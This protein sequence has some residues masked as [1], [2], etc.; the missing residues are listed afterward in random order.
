MKLSSVRDRSQDPVW[1]SFVVGV[2]LVEALLLQK[3]MCVE[4]KK[5][6]DVQALQHIML[7]N[8]A[9]KALSQDH[10]SFS[11]LEGSLNDTLVLLAKMAGIA[12]CS[13]VQSCLEAYVQGILS[14]K[15]LNLARAFSDHLLFCTDCQECLQATAHRC[16][17]TIRSEYQASL[18]PV[19]A[20]YTPPFSDSLS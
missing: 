4:Q 17:N 16:Q 18:E 6:G 14:Y 19:I 11:E 1:S 10:R 9:S 2:L 20:A 15:S 8:R 3:K 13:Q 5:T 7:L 12:H